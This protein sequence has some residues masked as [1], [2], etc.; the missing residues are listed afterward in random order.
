MDAQ[1]KELRKQ[2][3]IK[4]CQL[5]TQK[6]MAAVNPLKNDVVELRQLV[7]DRES[8]IIKLNDEVR[9]LSV[10]LDQEQK[11]PDKRCNACIQQQRLKSLRSDKA[12]ITDRDD[13][14][15][16]NLETKK[17]EET[18]EELKKLRDKYETMKRLCRI[19]N[20]KIVSLNQDIVEKENE[21]CNANKSVRQEV[22]VLK[23]QLKESEEKYSQIQKLYQSKGGPPKPKTV[24]RIVQTEL[25]EIVGFC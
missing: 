4:D 12:T 10:A 3:K 17:L 14:A 19:R 25:A 7:K 23:R 16:E 24:E 21:S 2:L 9:H 1:I 8:D 6:M 18:Q 15:V 22:S 5:N 20:E 13:S 11:R